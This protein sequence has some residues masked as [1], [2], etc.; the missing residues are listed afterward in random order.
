MLVLSAIR[1]ACR[2]LLPFPAADAGV[3]GFARPEIDPRTAALARM[4]AEIE[5]ALARRR[6]GR[7]ERRA[8]AEKGAATRIHQAYA[9]D[10]LLNEQ[11]DW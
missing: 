7:A 6:I 2:R 8:R 1:T 11:V 4:D 5:A 10:R 3:P 9:N